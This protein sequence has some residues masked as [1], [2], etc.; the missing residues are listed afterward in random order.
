MS[1]KFSLPLPVLL[2]SEHCVDRFDCGNEE[3]NRYLKKFAYYNNQNRSS[4]TFVTFHKKEVVGYYTLTI[5]SVSRRE[6]PQRVSKGLAKHP[7]PVFILARL[8]VTKKYHRQS[9]GQS[10]LKNALLRILGVADAIG[11]RAILVHAKNDQVKKFYKSFGFESS[12]I[13]Q[14]HLF[15]LLKDIKKTLGL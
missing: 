14:F 7:I 12:P 13:D 4:R 10:L 11:G 9:I 6:T 1:K 15:L 8:A 2:Q 3:L 5:G